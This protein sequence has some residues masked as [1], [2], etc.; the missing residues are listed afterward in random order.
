MTRQNVRAALAVGLTLLVAGTAYALVFLF[1][2]FRAGPDRAVVRS[3]LREDTVA[4]RC[5]VIR[6]EAALAVSRKQ[7]RPVVPE[8]T[9]LAAG[10]AAAILW[11]DAG[12]Y[13]RAALLLR[14][15]RE[16]QA[17]ECASPA[18][19]PRD[20]VAA[21]RRSLA[22]ALVRGD[23][24]AVN[25]S[26]H[27]LALGLLPGA[28]GPSRAQALREE[29]LSLEASGAA[30]CLVTAKGGAVWS[31]HADG[32][33]ALSP[34]RLDELDRSLLAAVLRSPVLVPSDTGRMVT[35][36]AWLL[37]AAA[38]EETGAL[39]PPGDVFT[40]KTP[41]G[42]FS[43]EVILLRTDSE[44]AVVVFRCRDA[45]E[46]VLDLR[47]LDAEAVMGRAEGLLVPREALQRDADS[48]YVCRIAGQLLVRA[49]VTPLTV[50]PEGVLVTSDGLRDGDS[51][52]LGPAE[53]SGMN[54]C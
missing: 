50:L 11:K 1:G 25:A 51:V 29:I 12:E 10:E 14:L 23:F 52:L 41:V 34:S 5:V 37:A 16:L 22:S 39:F 21:D 30:E 48:T 20:A 49:D 8:G 28:A 46:R 31:A 6:E 3:Y 2:R 9:R 17:L 32:W 7:L 44:G 13:M 43:G 24:D 35:G 4:L 27:S 15:R 40:L 18:P 19:A 42:V 26:A 45:A 33:E 53:D 54:I 47:I 38:D 36:G